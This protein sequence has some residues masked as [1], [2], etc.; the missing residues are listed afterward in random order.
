M[1]DLLDRAAHLHQRALTQCAR[2]RF[3]LA[4]KGLLRALGYLER[5]ELADQRRA[6]LIKVRVLTTLSSVEVELRGTARSAT[7]G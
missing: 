7:A 2:S 5:P 6:Q 3:D 4:D 1:P